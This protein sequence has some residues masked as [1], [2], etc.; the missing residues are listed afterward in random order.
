MS[1]Q[2]IEAQPIAGMLGAEITGADLSQPL[3]NAATDDILQALWDHKVI[4][5][6]DQQLTPEEHLRIAGMFGDIYR[7]PFIKA[8][9]GYPDI[10]DI[11]RE[12]ADAGKYNFGGT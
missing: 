3:S 8:R 6:R 7:V 5:L 12:P 9:D 11:V 4:F 1:Y 10:I 2:T